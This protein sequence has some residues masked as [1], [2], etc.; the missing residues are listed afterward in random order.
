MPASFGLKLGWLNQGRGGR[1]GGEARISHEP[2]SGQRAAQSDGRVPGRASSISLGPS[3]YVM[4]LRGKN[5][6]DAHQSVASERRTGS[7]SA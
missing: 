1:D 3:F 4:S 2:W 7:G 5:D 6:A